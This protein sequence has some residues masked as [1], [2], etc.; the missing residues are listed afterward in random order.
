MYCNVTFIRW[1]DA[2]TVT[3]LIRVLVS[4]GFI[5]QLKPVTSSLHLPK[6]EPPVRDFC[7]SMNTFR[8]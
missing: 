7:V 3:I 6:G 1:T 4:E 2:R 8:Y 5:L